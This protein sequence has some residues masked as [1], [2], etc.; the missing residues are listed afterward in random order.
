MTNTEIAYQMLNAEDVAQRVRNYLRWA[1]ETE[2]TDEE[3]KYMRP[4][5]SQIQYLKRIVDR[6]NEDVNGGE[7]G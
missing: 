6:V 4:A 1:K 7:V 3:E 2:G 5:R